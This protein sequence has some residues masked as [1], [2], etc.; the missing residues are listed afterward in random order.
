ML[1]ISTWARTFSLHHPI[2]AA[3]TPNPLGYRQRPET[4]WNFVYYGKQFNSA[5]IADETRDFPCI[6]VLITDSKSAPPV[7]WSVLVTQAEGANSNQDGV[8]G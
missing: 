8:Q 3:P 4:V 2:I 6:A 5:D 1:N 7:F